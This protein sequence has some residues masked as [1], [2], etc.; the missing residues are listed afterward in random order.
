MRENSWIEQDPLDKNLARCIR[1]CIRDLDDL[2]QAAQLR[3]KQAGADAKPSDVTRDARLAMLIFEKQ[4]DIAL[5]AMKQNV[6]NALAIRK[7][8]VEA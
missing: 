6:G 8:N 3:V 4:A 5:A 7:A 1:D 2:A